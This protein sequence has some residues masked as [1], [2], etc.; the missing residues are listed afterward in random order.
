MALIS[1]SQTFWR[2]FMTN[3]TGYYSTSHNHNVG[4]NG[5][6]VVVSLTPS[7]KFNTLN[8]GGVNLTLVSEELIQTTITGN[9]AHYQVWILENPTA[10]LNTL[11]GIPNFAS[12][13]ASYNG[14]AHFSI[15]SFTDCGGLGNVAS[16]ENTTGVTTTSIDI[17]QNSVILVRTTANNNTGAYIQIPE[18]TNRTFMYNTTIS[19]NT[20][21]VSARTMGARTPSLSAGNTS[22]K[23][24]AGG[25]I[26]LRALEVKEYVA[27][28][29]PTTSRRIIIC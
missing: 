3:A 12:F 22:I 25:N 11:S 28:P 14:Y 4:S 15:H 10:G 16:S 1:G 18:G 20:P 24:A 21:S 8:Y 29:P 19:L 23:A 27:P 6:L 9:P 2:P 26:V 13:G 5:Y 17:S 7:G